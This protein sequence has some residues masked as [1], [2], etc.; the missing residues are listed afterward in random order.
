V[1]ADKLGRKIRCPRC[2]ALFRVSDAGDATPPPARP[3]RGLTAAVVTGGVVAGAVVAFAL[4]SA[5]L[6]RG[7]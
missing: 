6:P 3:G 5:L 2:R 4:A 1:P 7:G